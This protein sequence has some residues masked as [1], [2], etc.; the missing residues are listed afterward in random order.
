MKKLFFILIFVLSS[1]AYAVS[2]HIKNG[3]EYTNVLR[4]LT[5]SEWT[6]IGDDGNCRPSSMCII[7]FADKNGSKLNVILSINK[8]ASTMNDSVVAAW[9]VMKDR[10]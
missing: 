7:S 2:V 9:G 1:S 3:M 8:D 5:E 6:Y 10:R 4:S